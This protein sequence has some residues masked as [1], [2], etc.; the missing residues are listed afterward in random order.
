MAMDIVYG[1]FS[2]REKDLAVPLISLDTQ[3]STTAAGYLIGGTLGITLEGKIVAD[4]TN[5]ADNY[6][7]NAPG[8]KADDPKWSSLFSDVD[9][10]SKGFQDDY[11]KLAIICGDGHLKPLDLIL[12]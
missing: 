9:T 4:A 11:Q 1:G 6:D 7:P 8:S 12:I 2:F 10:I 5:S 3:L